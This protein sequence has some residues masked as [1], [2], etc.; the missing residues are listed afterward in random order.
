M[1]EGEDQVDQLHAMRFDR[2][3]GPGLQMY[4]AQDQSHSFPRETAS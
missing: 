3:I 1:Q 4:G 2:E